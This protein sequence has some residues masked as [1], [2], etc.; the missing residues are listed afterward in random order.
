MPL[1]NCSQCNCVENTACGRYWGRKAEDKPVLCSEC[2]TGTWHHKFPK[3]SAV[4]M[5]VADDGFLWGREELKH[6]SHRT[7][8]VG[9]IG[10]DGSVRPL[11]TD[12]G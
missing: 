7:S 11:E 9:V 1:F 2:S 4:G 3:K 6:L 5:L 12:H 8:I 10:E